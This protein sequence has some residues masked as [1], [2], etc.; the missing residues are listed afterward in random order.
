VTETPH[1]KHS[2]VNPHSFS[3]T[4]SSL[5]PPNN[6]HPHIEVSYP[7]AYELRLVQTPIVTEHSKF[8]P[9]EFEEGKASIIHKIIF[10]SSGEDAL[11]NSS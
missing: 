1:K 9:N 11:G 6:D 3:S 10:E 5:F 2:S 8:L 4:L 7:N